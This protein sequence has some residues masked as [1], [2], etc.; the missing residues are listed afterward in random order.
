V[1]ERST[2][3]QQL[4]MAHEISHLR[5][6]D[7]LLL[8]AALSALA[9]LPWNP[10]LWWQLHRLRYAIEVDCDARVLN[11]GHEAQA[12]GEAL[13]EV[14]RRRSGFVGIVAGM[15][16]SKTL[17]EQR[18]EIMAQR[19]RRPWTLG[20]AAL[21]ALAIALAAG[22]TQIAPPDARSGR[23]EISVDLATLDRYVGKYQLART[24]NILSITRDGDQLSA[25][26]TGQA[27]LPIYAESPTEFFWK[28]VDAQ[29]TFSSVGPGLAANATIHQ[30]GADLTA[31]RL[32]D[33]T[34]QALEKSLKDRIAN[35][36]P[37]QGSELAL[38][39]TI[40]ALQSGVPNYADMTPAMQDATR[41]Q[42]RVLNSSVA[43]LGAIQTVEFKGV[44]E[45]G[46]DRYVITYQSGK[47][48]QCLIALDA[49][50]LI[51]GMWIF[52]PF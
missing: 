6:R 25:Q 5:E 48:S 51:A 41:Q 29:V 1:L 12:Y 43:G 8:T 49:N 33:A 9:L 27:S 11:S 13:I 30:N 35:S 21:C 24:T 15:S 44:Q 39:R 37:Q 3:E 32:D 17:L 42:L 46:A 20:F 28:A 23:K 36:T 31:M 19:N 50:G 22:A 34:A 52:P 38:R 4:I 2:A 26:L 45:G 10:A 18:I 47:E 16:E 14:G 40:A 7:P